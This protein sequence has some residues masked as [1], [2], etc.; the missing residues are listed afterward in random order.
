LQRSAQ[1]TD[2]APHQREQRPVRIILFGRQPGAAGT[3][4]DGV[5]RHGRFQTEPDRL[6]EFGEKGVLD[7]LVRFAHRQ[8]DAN[9]RPRS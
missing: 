6:D 5:E 1:R 3:N 9:R 8:R 4:I 2:D 7:G